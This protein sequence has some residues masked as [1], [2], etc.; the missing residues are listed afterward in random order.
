ME[1]NLR[2]W[3]EVLADPD[4]AKVEGRIETDRHG[5]II[6][7]P[8]PGSA[9]GSR[10]AEI[11]FQLR[12]LLGGKTVTECPISTSDGVRAADVGWFSDVRYSRAFD[13]R[14]FLEAPEICVEVISPRNTDAEMDEKMALYFDAGASEVWFC[15][16]DGRM[17]HFG[18]EGR[19][20]KSLLCP[21]FPA[22]IAL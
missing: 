21:D 9:H 12:V 3:E 1:F 6:M 10:Q 13:R 5:C 15:D 20:E 18:S 4:L 16:E 11:A 14:C 19:L 7:T 17:R 2:I 8:P 22:M